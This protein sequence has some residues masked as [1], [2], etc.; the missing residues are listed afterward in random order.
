M[1]TLLTVQEAFA[2]RQAG[3][4][5]VCRHVESELFEKLNNVSADTWFDPHYVFAIEI[6]TITLGGLEFTRPYALAELS[7]NDVIY[8]C[9]ASGKILKGNFNPDN[10]M[11][12]AGVKNGSVQRDEANAIAQVTA[13]RSLLNIEVE[14][15]VII[16][17]DF[18]IVDDEPKKSRGRKKKDAKTKLVETEQRDPEPK[19]INESSGAI[20][21]EIIAEI[22]DAS[23]S[24]ALEAVDQFVI[25]YMHKLS[26]EEINKI[27]LMI[28]EK[29]QNL[30]AQPAFAVPSQDEPKTTD[31]VTAIIQEYMVQLDGC[32]NEDDVMQ[33]R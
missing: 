24:I 23:T 11:L 20:L 25:D 32:A 2:A 7:A 14:A 30:S 9:G 19:Q 31:N 6:E 21:E 13:F 16:D 18:F 15:P 5:V 10:E 4:S 8:F 17:Y 1:H 29:R 28:D 22:N 26:G 33:V 12:V 27:K 3:K